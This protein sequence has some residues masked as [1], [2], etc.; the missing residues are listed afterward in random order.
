MDEEEIKRSIDAYAEQIRVT[1]GRLDL[2]ALIPTTEGEHPRVKLREVFVPPLLRADPPPVELPVELH[3]RLIEC[4]ELVEAEEEAPQVPG[5]SRDLWEQARQA[6]RDRPAVELLETLAAVESGRVVL[7]GDPGSGKSTLARYLALSLTASTL[8]EPLRPLSGLLPVV[9]ELRRYADADWRERSFEDFLAY[10]Y[11]HEGH[12]PSPD[13]LKCCLKRGKSLVI[14]DGLDELFDPRV[15]DD[16]TRRIKGFIARYPESRVVVTSRVIGYNRHTLD[17]AGFRHYMIQSL[18]ADQ[19]ASFTLRWYDAVCPEDKQEGERLRSR[20]S[21]A[22]RRSRPVREL[23]GNPLL[24]TILAIV[25]RRQRLPRDR[26]GV[27]RHAVNVL[28]SHWDEDAKHLDLASEIR[29]IA[30]L[31]DRDRREMLERLARHMQAGEDGIAGNHILGEEIEKV[32]TEYLRD[33]LQLDLAPA[34]KVARAMVK[35]LRERNFILSLYGGQVYGFMHR[36]FLEYLAASDIVRRYEQR[37]LTGE[38]LLDGV[39]ARHA[40]DPAWHEV[41]LLIVGQL[42]D[43]VAAPAI[44]KILSLP[45]D[46]K[47]QSEAPPTVLALRALTEVRRVGA[48]K[49]QSIQTARA[50]TRYW[51]QFHVVPI[52]V[53]ADTDASFRSLGPLWVGGNHIRRWLHASGGGIRSSTV[54]YGLFADMDVLLTIAS[55]AWQPAARAGVLPHLAQKWPREDKVLNF[56]RG[57]ALD[58]PH[59]FVRSDAL[60]VLATVWVEDPAIREFIKNRAIEDDDD[61]VRRW[62]LN[63]LAFHWPDDPAVRELIE[64]QVTDDAHYYV[65]SNALSILAEHWGDGPKV[66]DLIQERALEDPHEYV[67]SFAL[68]RLLRHWIDPAVREL[69]EQ[70]VTDDA[71]NYVRS[72]ALSI[73]AEHWGGDP[74]VRD[75]IERRAVED[76]D[77][78]AR[79]RAL[80]ALAGFWGDDSAVREL[81]QRRV[82]ED[83]HEHVRSDALDAL[84]EHWGDDTTVREL[85]EHHATDDP[86]EFTRRWAIVT[87]AQHW[88]ESRSVFELIYKRASEDQ[89]EDVR[90]SAL[91]ALAEHWPDDPAVRELVEDRS[92]RDPKAEVRNRALVVL[93]ETWTEKPVIEK[94]IR[95]LRERACLGDPADEGDFLRN[96][97]VESPHPEVRIE[98]ARLLASLWSGE[99]RTIP[100]LR[101]QEEVDPEEKVREAIAL[102]VPMAESYALVHERIS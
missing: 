49:E 57:R 45:V 30:D 102:V 92:T 55:W 39:F 17:A 18:S 66:R 87:L 42:G 37:D 65:R 19:I 54:A 74:N 62:T 15:R 69:I 63:T 34:R 89:H 101:R 90:I 41:L 71:H 95:D 84:A 14:F 64:Q 29:A 79:S 46:D 52:G 98:A 85:V 6:Y 28:V 8:A 47:E 67:R 81:I 82:K 53:T 61:Y 20:L 25:A 23:A 26:A 70:Q 77:E 9:I 80:E 73:L 21:E 60:D 99:A 83:P 78:H 58:D 36:A 40:S 51:E 3:R 31:D 32:F 91:R 7:L 48:V 12:A 68:L 33:T 2:E 96:P 76:P 72:I 38:D 4:G 11:E 43:K 44:E 94:I 86:H 59:G 13:L 50:L 22:I 100:L 88:A 27:Y 97:L 1:Y 24:L 93:A 75:L 56:L 16:V 10:V 5:M 35:Q